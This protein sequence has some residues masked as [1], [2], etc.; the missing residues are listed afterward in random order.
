[1]FDQ[2]SQRAYQFD[3]SDDETEVTDVEEPLLV[4]SRPRT[5]TQDLPV[6]VD[7]QNDGKR[8]A[9]WHRAHASEMKTSCS[10]KD[11]PVPINYRADQPKNRRV[12]EHP[13]APCQCW[14]T[15]EWEEADALWLEKYGV[16]YTGPRP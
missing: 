13:L 3:F 11:K 1:M 6:H 5:A 16:P 8:P 15:A 2:S 9:G 14:T 10:T 12:I 4:I 7:I